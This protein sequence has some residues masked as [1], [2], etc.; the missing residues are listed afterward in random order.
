MVMEKAL[1]SPLDCKV[2]QPV[3]PKGNQDIQWTWI[4]I[5]RTNAE[6][7]TPILWPIDVKNWLIWKDPDAGK[8]WGQEEKGMTEDEMVGWHHWLNGHGFW[9]T[10]GVGDGQGGLACCGLWGSKESDTTEWLNWLKVFLFLIF[11]GCSSLLSIWLYQFTFPLTMFKDCLFSMPSST[12]ISC[13][14]Y[15]NRAAAAAAKSLQSCSSLCHPIDGSPPGFPVPGIL[16]ARILE[17][18]AISF[19]NAWKWKVKVKSLSRVQ[20]FAT[21]WTAANQVPPSMRFSR[22]EYCRGLPLPSP[23][24]ILRGRDYILI[25]SICISLMMYEADH[26]FVYM[27]VICTFFYC[28]LAY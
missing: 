7:E 17:W 9:W 5:G 27:F 22:Q 6:A 28:F 19:S 26:L 12:F 3:H 1:E 4:F 8:D 10:L 24:T 18:V 13:A 23:I 25:M 11:W 2:I 16:Q 14:F 21:P 15:N 20:L